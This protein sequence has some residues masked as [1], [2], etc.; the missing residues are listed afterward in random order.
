MW[1]GGGAL[2][3]ILVFLLSW[4]IMLAILQPGNVVWPVTPADEAIKKV[5]ATN[6]GIFGFISFALYKLFGKKKA[7]KKEVVEETSAEADIDELINSIE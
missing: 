4:W 1:A 5:S 2:A 6:L 3:S 7:E